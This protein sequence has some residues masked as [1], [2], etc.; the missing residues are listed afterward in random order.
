MSFTWSSPLSYV[1]HELVTVDQTFRPSLPGCSEGSNLK[2][3]SSQNLLLS[4]IEWGSNK[5]SVGLL[6]WS[7]SPMGRLPLTSSPVDAHG[8]A[9]SWFLSIWRIYSGTMTLPAALSSN[10]HPRWEV[11]GKLPI[12]G[13][14]RWSSSSPWCP[15][16]KTFWVELCSKCD[17]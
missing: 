1:W 3:I 4:W 6:L 7:V 9:V 15:P 13:Y 2:W 8:T 12:G 11:R 10:V 16:Q 17:A 5:S 14:E